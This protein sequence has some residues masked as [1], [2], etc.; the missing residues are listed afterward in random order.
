MTSGNNIEDARKT[1][2]AFTGLVKWGTIVT[3]V[4]TCIVVLIIAS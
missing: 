2:S 4:V 3:A 1:Y